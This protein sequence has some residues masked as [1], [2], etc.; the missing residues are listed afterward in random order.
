MSTGVS[1]V[2]GFDTCPLRL[3]DS[4]GRV[5]HGNPCLGQPNPL[6]GDGAEHSRSLVI[7][8]W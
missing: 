3:A 6:R 1:D 8:G 5:N 2:G 4:M 7:N